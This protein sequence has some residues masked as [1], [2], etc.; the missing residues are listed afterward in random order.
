MQNSIHLFY[1]L[2]IYI[3]SIN[4]LEY[5][6][7]TLCVIIKFILILIYNINLKNR[8]ILLNLSV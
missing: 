8:K 1:L 2:F 4:G 6:I 7:K 5:N 3:Q